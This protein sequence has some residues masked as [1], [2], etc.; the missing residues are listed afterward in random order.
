[1]KMIPVICQ[2]LHAQYGQT[3]SAMPLA[4]KNYSQQITDE[5]IRYVAKISSINKYLP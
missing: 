5:L 3:K 4:I 1:M 2:Q